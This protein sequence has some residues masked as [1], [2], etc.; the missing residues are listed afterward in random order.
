VIWIS[1]NSRALRDDEGRLLG[2]EGT[3]MD[4]TARRQAETALQQAHDELETRVA[5]RTAELAD[6]IESLR[7]EIAERERAEAVLQQRERELRMIAENS[8]DIISRFDRELRNRFISP[9]VERLLGIPPRRFWKNPP[10]DEYAGGTGRVLA[11]KA[12]PC[13]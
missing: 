7:E 12:T 9:A 8:P 2:Y 10:R 4:I 11:G 13:L 6:V 5:A 3:V 1:E